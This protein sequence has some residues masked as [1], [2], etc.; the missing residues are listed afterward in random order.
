MKSNPLRNWSDQELI[1]LFMHMPKHRK[2]LEY[3]FVRQMTVIEISQRL[4][5]PINRV[6]RQLDRAIEQARRFF[7]RREETTNYVDTVWRSQNE[8]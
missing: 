8:D 6:Y 4:K 3:R 7:L 5:M 1:Y 2:I